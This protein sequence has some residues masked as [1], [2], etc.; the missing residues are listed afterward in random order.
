MICTRNVLVGD[1]MLFIYLTVQCFA[2]EDG[3]GDDNGGNADGEKD[4]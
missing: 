3:Y 2:D 4:E 1:R